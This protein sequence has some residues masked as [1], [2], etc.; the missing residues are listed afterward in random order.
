[1]QQGRETTAMSPSST[2]D[3]A[4]GD[5][6]RYTLYLTVYFILDVAGGD[7]RPTLVWRGEEGIKYRVEQVTPRLERR[8]RGLAGGW[9]VCVCVCGSDVVSCRVAC[10]VAYQMPYQTSSQMSCLTS[11]AQSCVG[12]VSDLHWR[13]QSAL[14]APASYGRAQRRAVGWRSAE[15]R[16]CASCR[17]QP[18]FL[19]LG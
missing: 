17:L 19:A 11:P 7:P 2:L 10:R 14:P 1:V 16:R 18:F 3:V 4:G 5:P 8:G 9:C 6:R 12:G 15:K 13:H